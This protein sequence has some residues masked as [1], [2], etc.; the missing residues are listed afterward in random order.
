MRQFNI[1][2]VLVLSVVCAACSQLPMAN[3]IEDSVAVGYLTIESIANTTATAYGN[4]WISR[5]EKLRIRDSLQRA[6][7]T[8]G[9]AR[10]YL[11]LG[12][13]DSARSSLLAA[14]VILDGLEQILQESQP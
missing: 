11:S 13:P 8:L 6:H 14:E 10:A 2:T 7:D 3:N 4:D 12:Q 9:Q 1:Y 5:E